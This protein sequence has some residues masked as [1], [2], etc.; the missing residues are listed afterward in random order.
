MDW[1]THP[2]LRPIQQH[3]KNLYKELLD[4]AGRNKKT[5]HDIAENN[6]KIKELHNRLHKKQEDVAYC[7]R[8]LEN[9]E[10][11]RLSVHTRGR[12]LSRPI[13]YCIR[14][15]LARVPARLKK[16]APRAASSRE[17]WWRGSDSMPRA[18]ANDS[19]GAKERVQWKW[20]AEAA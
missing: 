4:E 9:F 13:L 14:I 17:A 12:Y 6:E 5:I 18:L 10:F 1:C 7:Q 8:Q 3:V 2:T 11:V 19:G 15:S 16:P 20:L